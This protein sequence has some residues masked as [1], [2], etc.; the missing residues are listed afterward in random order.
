MSKTARTPRTWSDIE[1][2][3]IRISGPII[4]ATDLLAEA[5]HETDTVLNL[6]EGTIYNISEQCCMGLLEIKDLFYE[7]AELY[8]NAKE[9]R[10]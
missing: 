7:L 3:F 2:D 8:S 4:A 1:G 10:S 6:R 9:R 5:T